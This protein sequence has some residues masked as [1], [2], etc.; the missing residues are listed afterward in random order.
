MQAR[1][2]DM[3]NNWDLQCLMVYPRYSRAPHGTRR[4][5]SSPWGF[6]MYS[7]SQKYLPTLQAPSATPSLLQSG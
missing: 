4:P 2:P 3:E 6:S 5:G 1:P 7:G